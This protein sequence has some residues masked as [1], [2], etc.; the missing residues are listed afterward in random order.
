MKINEFIKQSLLDV[1]QGLKDAQAA[2]VKI[3]SAGPDSSEV[4]VS[5]SIGVEV[6]KKGGV[7]LSVFNGAAGKSTANRLE[8]SVDAQLLP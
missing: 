3:S 1:A 4:R 2:G 6:E 7:V 8:F 5:F